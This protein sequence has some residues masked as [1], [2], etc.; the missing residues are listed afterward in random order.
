MADPFVRSDFTIVADFDNGAIVFNDVVAFSATF[1]LNSIP[2]ASLVVASGYN[3]RTGEPATIHNVVNILKPRIP[4]K[5]TLTVNTT[6]GLLAKMPAGIYVIF[7]G[8]YAG[9]G[10]QRSNTNSSY[11]LHLIHWLDDL[12]CSSMLNGNW[13]VGAPQNLASAAYARATLPAGDTGQHGGGDNNSA[14]PIIKTAT[15]SGLET[16][17][18]GSVLKPM[19]D[20]IRKFPHPSEQNS[21]NLDLDPE[22]NGNNA[23]AA[24]ALVRMP[25]SAPKPSKLAMNLD[26]VNARAIEC[27]TNSGITSMALNSIGYTS[28]WGKLVGEFAPSFLFAVSP[29][30]EFANVIPFFAGLRTPWKIIKG[31]EYNYAAFNASVAA[32][33]ESV[34]IFYGVQTTSGIAPAGSITFAPM[35]YY[36]PW[37]RFPRPNTDFRGQILIKEPPAWLASPIPENVFAQG[38]VGITDT[39]SGGAVD[40]G[41]KGSLPAGTISPADTEKNFQTTILNRFA[42][43]WYQSEV[44]SQRYGELSG[45]LR[46]DIA[47]GS[48]IKI[49]TPD[50]KIG[51]EVPLYA[52]VA[53]VSCVINAEQHTAGTSFTLTN[54][55]TDYEN[56]ND[57]LTSD[58]TPLYKESWPGGPLLPDIS[59]PLAPT[60]LPAG[61]TV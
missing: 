50:S 37:G 14:T 26:D 17:L 40:P 59:A 47:P 20:E 42:K 4:V 10:Y 28:F 36:E 2:T 61:P 21:E 60:E 39:P 58:D 31:D 49:M 33:I 5:V 23:A 56:S 16:D 46:F 51:D 38:S 24:K 13:S 8:Y 52:S 15:A 7:D 32:L 12:N 57:I 44:L 3:M 53:Q 9:M 29:G 35:S 43:H 30:V 22:S 45:K 6:D 54:L 1:G 41:A 34:D 27:A 48:V 18:W 55:R 19:F 11:T 25:G